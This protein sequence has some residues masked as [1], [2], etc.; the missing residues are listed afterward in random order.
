ML[1]GLQQ[2]DINLHD[3]TGLHKIY[4]SGD[5]R[6]YWSQGGP[7]IRGEDDESQLTARKVL[8]ISDILVASEQQIEPRLLSRV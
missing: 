1:T 5:P 3:L 6:C 7:V 8:L 4:G 2:W